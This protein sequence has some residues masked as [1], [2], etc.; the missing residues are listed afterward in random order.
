MYVIAIGAEIPDTI[1]SVTVARRGY[2]SM[3]VS[4]SCGSQIINIL[5]GLGLPWTL[6]CLSGKNIKV[7]DHEQIQVMAYFQSANVLVFVSIILFTTYKTWKRGDHSKASL[8][9]R[10]G[11]VLVCMYVAVLCIYPFFVFLGGSSKPAEPQ[12][13]HRMLG[14]QWHRQ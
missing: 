6:S 10:K 7:G 2:G 5:I 3:A 13:S 14:S 12:T 4:N 8:G 1:Q 11:T 9:K